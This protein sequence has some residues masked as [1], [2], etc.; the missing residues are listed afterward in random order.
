MK[1]AIIEDGGK[2]YKAIEGN[3]IQVDRVKHEVGDKVDLERVLLVV[4]EKEVHIGKPL[5]EGAKV[6]ATIADHVKGPK[7]VVFKYKPRNRYRV[8]TGHRQKY[9]QLHIDSIKVSKKKRGKD[10]A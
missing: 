2:Q 4:D 1:Y 7:I 3:T 6:K 9:T 8:K 10:G 5:V